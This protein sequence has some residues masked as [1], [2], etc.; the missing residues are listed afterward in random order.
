METPTNPPPKKRSINT[1]FLIAVVG[2][3][4]FGAGVDLLVRHEGGNWG[5]ILTIGGAVVLGI[6][7]W[8]GSGGRSQAR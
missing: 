5:W 3:L 1:A 4:V 6:A 8:C 7:I 2:L